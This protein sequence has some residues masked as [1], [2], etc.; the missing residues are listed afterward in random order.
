[1][2]AN[3]KEACPGASEY[4]AEHPDLHWQ[5]SPLG[6]RVAVL[7]GVAVFTVLCCHRKAHLVSGVCNHYS[8]WDT[9]LL[10]RS[11]R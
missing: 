1:M 7:A 8:C 5:F 2:V 11:K 3:L 4:I 10:R 6:F 9:M